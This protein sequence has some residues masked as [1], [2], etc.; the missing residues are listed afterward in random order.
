MPSKRRTQS[1]VRG[2]RKS[3]SPGRRARSP[4]RKMRGGTLPAKKK[5]KRKAA[6]PKMTELDKMIR[7]A[8]VAHDLIKSVMEKVNIMEY[9]TD[10]LRST[11]VALM[12]YPG[13]FSQEVK[14]IVKDAREGDPEDFDEIVPGWA[15][16]NGSVATVKLERL[17]KLLA[18]TTKELATDQ[19]N[20]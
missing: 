16:A 9:D 11:P 12:V 20:Q 6:A 17:A 3:S 5:P 14:S 13:E 18:D 2:G 10:R 19:W 1:P 8:K 4:G 7:D 15:L